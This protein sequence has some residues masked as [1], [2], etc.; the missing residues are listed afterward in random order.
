MKQYINFVWILVLFLFGSMSAEISGTKTV[1]ITGGAGFIGSHVNEALNEEGYNTIIIDNLSTGNRQTI[2]H[3]TLIEGD[4]G[5]ATLL[6]EIF[7]K[8]SIDAVM[9]FAA[10]IEVGESV[11]NPFKYYENNVSK[12]LV[13]L[14]A[15]CRHNVKSFIFS[16]SAAIFGE[17]QG[18][19]VLVSEEFPKAPINP[20]GRSK[21]IVEQ[22]LPDFDV[23]HGLKF[24]CLR[25]FNA[26]GGDPKGNIKSY[27]KASNLIQIVLKQLQIPNG[28]VTIFGTDYP[29][30]DGSGIRDY[31][32][33]MDISQAHIAAMKRLLAG[34]ISVTYNLGNG[35]GY[36]VKEVIATAE[37]VTGHNLN[38]IEGT[39]RPG[40]PASVVSD[41]TKAK[42][43]LNWNPNYPELETMIKHAWNALPTHAN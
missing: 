33:V 34:G 9:H 31:I 37:T 5:D 13:L 20:Y 17:I 32:H 43:E 12:T 39:R 7:S 41:S 40:D 30:H 29:T 10:Y 8:Y 25:Y 3:G 23:A 35:K 6:D 21:L 27:K 38:V 22:M 16:S 24:C 4:I 15:M 19:N 14:D 11:N 42:N 36:S 28:Q 1:L 26:A 2:L 18:D